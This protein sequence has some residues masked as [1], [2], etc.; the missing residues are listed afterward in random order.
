MDGDCGV[1]YMHE[2][3]PKPDIITYNALLHCC[4]AC[5]QAQIAEELLGDMRTHGIAPDLRSFGAVLTACANACEVGRA[6]RVLRAM[7]AAGIP[8][9]VRACTSVMSACMYEGS[10][11][12]VQLVRHAICLR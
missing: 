11:H 8:A 7:E 9:N 2:S 3:G 10:A 1:Q 6:Q 12:S 5:G 4:A